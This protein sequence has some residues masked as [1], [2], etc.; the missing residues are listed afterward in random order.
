MDGV[1][2]SDETV[3]GTS[4]GDGGTDENGDTGQT[5]AEDV[6]HTD[7][8]G[9]VLLRDDN[10]GAYTLETSCT[11]CLLSVSVERWTAAS[12]V[13]AREPIS[14]S[15]LLGTRPNGDPVDIA[16]FSLEDAAGSSYAFDVVALVEVIPGATFEKR[17]SAFVAF[18]TDG[19]FSRITWEQW[20]CTTTYVSCGTSPEGQPSIIFLPTTAVSEVQP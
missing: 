1:H 6:D 15:P 20:V 16:S 8:I 10:T 19:T 4:S 13:R 18:A 17:Q 11:G 9:L 7:D 14:V 12:D 3:S 2:E 5:V